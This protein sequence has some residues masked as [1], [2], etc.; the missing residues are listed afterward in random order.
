MPSFET[1]AQQYFQQRPSHSQTGSTL[2]TLM[3]ATPGLCLVASTSPLLRRRLLA[4]L[5]TIEI[6]KQVDAVPGSAPMIGIYP[7]AGPLDMV[8][9]LMS[10]DGLFVASEVDLLNDGLF[11]S[12]PSSFDQLTTLN[13]VAALATGSSERLHY[14]HKITSF[15]SVTIALQQAVAGS[16][17][18]L[19][20]VHALT[21]TPGGTLLSSLRDL[22]NIAHVHNVTCYV[23][24]CAAQDY[25]SV[26]H[27]ALWRELHPSLSGAE[28]F[29]D[30][31]V[32]L[33][34]L[35]SSS[36]GDEDIVRYRHTT[37]TTLGWT[38]QEL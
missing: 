38:E 7:N 4:C 17:F 19:E 26:E 27:N 33:T 5:A 8:R 12:A 9:S 22:R 21:P 1:A 16:V 31:L 2:E 36:D 24:G 29:V 18:F 23:G 34:V 10:L 28:T 25:T 32:N 20:N 30:S 15:S 11:V 6:R 13:Q 35:H 37:P 14:D 3:L